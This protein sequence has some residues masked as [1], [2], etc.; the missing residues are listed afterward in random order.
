MTSRTARI[1]SF[2]VCAAVISVVLLGACENREQKPKVAA[3]SPIGAAHAQQ[4]DTVVPPAAITGAM[5]SV[6]EAF[7][8]FAASSSLAQIEAAR[9]ALKAARSDDVR[10]YAQRVMREHTHAGE[11]LRRIVVPRGLKLPSAPTGRHADMVTK[12]SGVAARDLE[13]AFLQRFGLDAHKEAIALFERHAAEGRSP[14]VQRHAQ[15]MLPVLR[16][17]MAAA[18]KLIHAAAAAR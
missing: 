4:V 8:L 16:E 12:L 2:I 5:A 11:Q 13:E 1:H 15:D 3:L 6:D 10:D 7:A 14:E 17:L 18:H 9:F